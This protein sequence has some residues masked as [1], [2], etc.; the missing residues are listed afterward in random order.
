MRLAPELRAISLERSLQRFEKDDAGRLGNLYAARLSRDRK[1]RVRRRG[2]RRTICGPQPRGARTGEADRGLRRSSGACQRFDAQSVPHFEW[3]KLPGEAPAH[4]AIDVGDGVGN[5][6]NAA[7]GVET[8]LGDEFPKELL[9][10]VAWLTGDSGRQNG[11]EAAREYRRSC[12][13]FRAKQ[14][15]PFSGDDTP[16][17]RDREPGFLC[18]APF[19]TR[20]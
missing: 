11:A 8:S 4:G 7:S 15:A 5:F 16:W 12:G 6:G 17:W 13:P 3:A 14:S 18:R 19:L 10:L 1:P 20:W 2:I 9:G